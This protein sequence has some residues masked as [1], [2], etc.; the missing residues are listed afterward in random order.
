MN[1]EMTGYKENTKIDIIIPTYN[2]GKYLPG[3]LTSIKNQTYPHYTCTVIDDHSLDNT[4]AIVK[5]QFPWVQVIEQAENYG[6][7]YNR[8]I[9]IRTGHS[10]YIVIFDD[11]VFVEDAEWLAKALHVMEEH[12]NIGQLASMIVK[13][14]DKEILLD[15]GVYRLGCILGGFYYNYSKAHTDG[16]YEISRIVLGSCS[17]GTILRRDVFEMVGEFDPKYFYPV[18]DIDLSMRIHLVGYDVLYEPSLV[19]YHFESQAMGKD[20]QRKMYLYRRN[21]LLTLVENYPLGCIA[22][23]CYSI[24]TEKLVVPFLM[25]IGQLVKRTE[26]R[27]ELQE[28]KD[29]IKTFLFLMKQTLSILEKRRTFD[30]VR[31]KSRAYLLE[32]EEA[33]MKFMT[34]PSIEEKISKVSWYHSY[35]LLPGVITP[36]IC[37]FNAKS[38]L[39]WLG[40]P[41]NL[42]GKRALDIGTWDGPAA[43]ELEARGAEVV[44]LDIQDPNRT[45]FNTAKE[46]LQS[47]V[48]YIQG[49]VYELS[50]LLSGKGSFD[51]ICF[52]GVFYH[53]KDPVMAFEEIEKML[54]EDGVVLFEG[55]CCLHYAETIEGEP[56]AQ[57]LL[58]SLAR[59]NAAEI[60]L[61]LFY[62][63]KYKNDHSNWFIPN[64]ACFDS[65]LRAAG[66]EC[67]QHW[68]V[69]DPDQRPHPVQRISGIA[70]KSLQSRSIEHGLM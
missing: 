32:V 54:A 28:T 19:T 55:E 63:G 64:V 65:W 49:S 52:F 36:G 3:L 4:V 2:G 9:A 29:Y 38:L 22:R 50:Q 45:G 31:K 5:E 15:C 61:T 70:K 57:E 24:F 51:I 46:I 56:I 26:Q 62:S 6:P 18:E 27:V 43:F 17:A 69:T 11:D 25:F 10:P 40:I 47:K 42:S 30:R 53:L 39:D 21:C 7:A 23:I 16:K 14:S 8:N 13:G 20:I 1:S 67:V 35:E 34:P 41:R 59:L 33:S 48:T 66:L 60:P 58:E 68:L 44:A 12:P 37:Q